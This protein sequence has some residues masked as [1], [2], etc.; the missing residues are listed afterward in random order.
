MISIIYNSL[1]TGNHKKGNKT[2]DHQVIVM[3]TG[4][5]RLSTWLQMTTVVTHGWRLAGRLNDFVTEWE[6]DVAPW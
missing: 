1:Y 2:V 6:R 5:Y 4:P 3:N